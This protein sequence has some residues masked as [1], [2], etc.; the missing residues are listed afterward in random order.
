M[1]RLKRNSQ[2]LHCEREKVPACFRSFLL[3]SSQSKKKDNSS[4]KIT[5]DQ[6]STSISPTVVSII[7]RPLVGSAMVAGKVGPTET[8]TERSEAESNPQ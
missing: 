8:R 7:T 2:T 5:F 3:E 6:S 1:R 4:K